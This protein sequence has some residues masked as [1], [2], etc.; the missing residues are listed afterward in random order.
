MTGPDLFFWLFSAVLVLASVFVVSARSP[1]HAVFFLILAFLN[2]AGLFLLLGAEF[3]GM[4]MLIV[5]VG[6]VAVLF[7]FVVMTLDAG[8]PAG[9]L[10]TRLPAALAA[11]A[12]LLLELALVARAGG[13]AGP[14]VPLPGGVSNTRALGRLIYTD[15]AALFELAG[16]ILLVALIGAIVLAHRRRPGVR[17]QDPVRQTAR[18]RGDSIRLERPAV[19]AGVPERGA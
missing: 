16:A 4:M 11:G 15:Y 13:P 19:G 7:L 6:A 18:R 12:I 14:P 2:A 8:P 17:R 9:R 3:L 1:V 5:Y 10:R